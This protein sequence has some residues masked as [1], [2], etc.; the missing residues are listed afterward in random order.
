[1]V[2]THANSCR[3]FLI[4][5]YVLP[6]SK[7]GMFQVHVTGASTSNVMGTNLLHDLNNYQFS[8]DPPFPMRNISSRLAA[9]SPG[10]YTQGIYPTTPKMNIQLGYLTSTQCDIGEPFSCRPTLPGNSSASQHTGTSNI[11]RHAYMTASKDRTRPVCSNPS[12][13]T[14]IRIRH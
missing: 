3:P 9:S 12:M 5:T 7:Q 1:M 2:D 6:P 8:A 4:Q 14:F 13:P 11:R 10:T